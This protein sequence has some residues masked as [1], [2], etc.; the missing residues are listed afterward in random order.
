MLK[1]DVADLINA[2]SKGQAGSS[3]GGIFLK[4][5]IDEGQ[6]WAHLDIA[7]PSY[8]DRDIPEVPKG[9]TG[10]GVRTLLYYLYNIQE[11]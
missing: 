5:F 8:T 3:A 4:A 2:G 7:G 10:V 6:K 11:V 9:A 1:S